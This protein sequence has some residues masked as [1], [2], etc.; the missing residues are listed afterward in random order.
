M[1]DKTNKEP[2]KELKDPFKIDILPTHQITLKIS[3]NNFHNGE[4]WFSLSGNRN[5]SPSQIVQYD[6]VAKT[7]YE[8]YRSF[9]NNHVIEFNIRK[10]I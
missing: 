3:A 7:F 5:Q 8:A 4:Y 1:E 6:M 10:L 2:E 9:D